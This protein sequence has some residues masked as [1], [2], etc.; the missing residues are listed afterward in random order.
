M[1]KIRKA[2]KE[3]LDAMIDLWA[4]SINWR[5][6]NPRYGEDEL[7]PPVSYVPHLAERWSREIAGGMVMVAYE[8]DSLEG[9]CIYSAYTPY[10][11]EY[12]IVKHVS[13]NEVYMN[14]TAQDPE[15]ASKLIQEVAKWTRARRCKRLVIGI[16]S[17]RN[18]D[19]EDQC[20]R[21]GAQYTWTQGMNYSY[22]KYY[23]WHDLDMLCGE[24]Q[25]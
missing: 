7:G 4:E 13:L 18:D 2:V 1:L 3:D 11:P 25:G 8:G 5:F 17:T 22:W 21:L 10:K 15:V 19:L 23:E 24:R 20:I 12:N 16:S 9:F 6:K 14:S